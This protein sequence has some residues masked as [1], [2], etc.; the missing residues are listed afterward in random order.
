MPVGY[1]KIGYRYLFLPPACIRGPAFIC[2][3]RPRPRL[4]SEARPLIE[5]RSLFED[6]RYTP[7]INTHTALHTPKIYTQTALHTPMIYTHTHT[8]TTLH[9]QHYHTPM[10]YTLTH[11][12]TTTYT[13][14]SQTH[15]HTT[16]QRER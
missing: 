15:T 12:H 1:S 5:S 11:T 13:C 14:T 9:T 16:L 7:A 10:I 8:R 3:Y 6:L 2:P 4:L